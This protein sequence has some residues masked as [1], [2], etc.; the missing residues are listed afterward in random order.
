MHDEI[1]EWTA[2]LKPKQKKRTYEHFDS[3]VD[4]DNVQHF[5]KVSGTIRNL[6]THQF[7]PFIKFIKKEI[8]YRKGKAQKAQ[9]ST[10]ERPIMYASHLDAHIYGFY[11]HV[12]S[13]KYEEFIK[14]NDIGE[15]VIAYRKIINDKGNGRGKN[16]INFANEVFQSVQDM[17]DCVVIVADISKF[18]DSLNHSFLKNRLCAVLGT[19]RLSAEEYKVL[20]S[21]TAYRY[22]LKDKGNKSVYAK[23]V[24]QIAK[25]ITKKGY[26][27]AQAVYEFGRNIIKS[28]K[29]SIGIPQGSPA[30]GLLANIYLSKFD[31]GFKE[32]FP[33][34]MYRRYS[35]DVILICP[36][37]E[38]DKVFS[39]LLESIKSSLLEINP[40]KAFLA[41]FKKKD[42]GSVVCL[43]V[44]DGNKKSVSR[45]Y[46]DYLGFEF[47]GQTVLLRGKTLQRAYKKA[48]AKIGEFSLRQTEENPR[49]KH[50]SSPR[51]IHLKK[52]DTYINRS[53]RLMQTIGSNITSQ[54]NK[55]H[56][57]LLK[58]RRDSK[59]K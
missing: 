35:D 4:L 3:Q 22:A 24:S 46:L 44:Q 58:K 30:S 13:K 55:M 26:S 57:F 34:I 38:A 2:S 19:T 11:S 27:T 8:R 25:G 36:V 14:Q 32:K 47:N 53:D 37:D 21:L 15:N 1:Q 12:W 28:N 42:D 49:K 20:R 41:R 48:A 45:R 50:K 40:T 39:F 5:G 31:C 33:H 59:P 7:L 23:L 16:N 52:E 56:K 54:E 10:K 9:R 43:D 17:G 29:T 6:N 51:A 18:F